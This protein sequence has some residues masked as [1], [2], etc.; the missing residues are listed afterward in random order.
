M[1]GK[2]GI[3]AGMSMVID[4]LSQMQEMMQSDHDLIWEADV[5][6]CPTVKICLVQD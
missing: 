1:F 3:A 4:C 2:Q 5:G 6:L